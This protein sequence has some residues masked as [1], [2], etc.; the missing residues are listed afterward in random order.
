MMHAHG[1]RKVVCMW[2]QLIELS[3][4]KVMPAI[5]PQIQMIC[6]RDVEDAEQE[7]GG[8]NGGGSLKHFFPRS[9]WEV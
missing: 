6:R 2:E 9:S 5:R 3:K 1:N 4:A 7:Q 8:E